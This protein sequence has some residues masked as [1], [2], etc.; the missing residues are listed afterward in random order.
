[1]SVEGGLAPKKIGVMYVIRQIQSG[2]SQWPKWPK[3]WVTF[4]LDYLVALD[5]TRK[6]GRSQ[7]LYKS[8]SGLPYTHYYAAILKIG[9]FS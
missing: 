6:S 1:M 8:R 7:H 9:L 2:L 5:E 3:Q 4:D